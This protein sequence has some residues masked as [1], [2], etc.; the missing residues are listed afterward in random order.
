M[1]TDVADAPQAEA[2]VSQDTQSTDLEEAKT[3]LASFDASQAEGETDTQAADGTEADATPE[4]QDEDELAAI[5]A[6]AARLVEER[7]EAEEAERKKAEEA[8]RE[9]DAAKKAKETRK[10]QFDGFAP[11]LRGWLNQL[12][13]DPNANEANVNWVMEQFTGYNG[14]A[15]DAI[16]ENLITAYRH[17]GARL[18]P[19]EERGDFEATEHAGA[20]EFFDDL[21]ARITTKARKGYVKETA[22]ADLEAQAVVTLKNRFRKNPAALDAFVNSLN[23]PSLTGTSIQGGTGR[24]FASED[25]LNT[26]WIDKTITREV[27]ARE[28]KRLTGRDL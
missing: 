6:K 28:Y 14:I 27:Y 15:D 8:N 18:L 4:T 10:Q 23:G 16:R 24:Q 26:A 19:E 1:T 2:P 7:R 17:W 3:L 5:E 13:T 9:A 22:Q 21:E 20:K 25:A 12:L 11:N